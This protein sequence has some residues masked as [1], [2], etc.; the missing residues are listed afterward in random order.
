MYLSHQSFGTTFTFNIILAFRKQRKE[1][2][3][4]KYYKSMGMGFISKN[5]VE[6]RLRR[7]LLK[8]GTI[9]STVH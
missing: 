9:F 4:I 2:I 3:K 7:R 8:A 6:S 5:I 1:S